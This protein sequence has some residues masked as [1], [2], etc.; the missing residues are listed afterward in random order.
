MSMQHTSMNDTATSDRAPNDTASDA[1]EHR[2]WRD[3][4]ADHIGLDVRQKLDVYAS[5][6]RSAT[7]RDATYWAEIVFSAGIATMG[8][9]L[10]SPAV[11][12]GA[13]LISPLM[14][15]IM[16]AGL[17]LAAGDFIL[18][19]RA[20]T[21]IVVSCVVAVTFATLLVALLPFREMTGEIAARTHPNTLDLLVA[22]FS[23]AVGALATS[24]SLRGVA[25]SIPG[26]A[27]AVALMPPLCV[28][29]YGI[30]VLLTVDRAQGIS[31]M[32][33]GALLFATN[34]IAITFSSMLVF[35]AL[36]VDAAP[37]RARIREWRASDPENAMVRGVLD[38]L[39]MAKAMARI[40]SLPA[41]V[42]ILVILIAAVSVPLA[43]SF[44]ALS[45]EIAQRNE[46][47]A[48]QR[49]AADAWQ[50]RFGRTASGEPRS[51]IDELEATKDPDGRTALMM[52]VFTSRAASAE[53]RRSY[54]EALARSLRRDPDTIAF[55]LVEIPTSGYEIATRSKPAAPAAVPLDQQLDAARDRAVATLAP[56]PLPRGA[57]LLDSAITLRTRGADVTLTYLAAAPFSADAQSLIARDVQSRLAIGDARILLQWIPQTLPIRFTGRST[58]IPDTAQSQLTSLAERVNESP[59]LHVTIEAPAATPRLTA[60]AAAI[61]TTLRTAALAESRM[62]TVTAPTLPEDLNTIVVRFGV[63]RP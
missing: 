15:P 2:A 3:W 48:I 59:A 61:A 63:R 52:R 23:G 57:T 30:G 28:T 45:G 50:Q 55:T 44:D 46:L 20:V 21:S 12:I 24:K 36:H 25:T 37:V 6:A 1:P 39:A 58:S 33:G 8:L 7:L 60:R 27:I 41:R 9:V 42:A 22:L 13:M 47:N 49:Q 26:V 11:I 62:T 53:E 5:V 10:G 19:V 40:G 16:A 38:R 18:T 31:V 17:A 32:G 14:G 43:R 29:G 4:L 35:L 34:L 56:T 54:V 51:Y